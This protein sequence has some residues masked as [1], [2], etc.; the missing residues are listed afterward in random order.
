MLFLPLHL[1]KRRLKQRCARVKRRITPGHAALHLH[2]HAQRPRRRQIL[3]VGRTGQLQKQRI[4]A[5]G[6]QRLLP[7]HARG[8]SVEDQVRRRRRARQLRQ[9]HGMRSHRVRRLH[10]PLAARADDHERAHRAKPRAERPTDAPVAGDQAGA[11]QQRALHPLHRPA[12]GALGGQ[13][14]VRPQKRLVPP[15]IERM[16]RLRHVLRSHPATVHEQAARRNP[17]KHDL[18]RHALVRRRHNQHSVAEAVRPREHDHVR[19]VVPREAAVRAP[20][21]LPSGVKRRLRR[22]LHAPVSA[23]GK[24]SQFHPLPARVCKARRAHAGQTG[25]ARR[26]LLF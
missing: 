3:A 24:Q 15:R 19:R 25:R 11:A 12:N 14:R 23:N 16:P 8:H 17:C 2:A 6:P 1:P 4:R 9:R 26:Q 20:V 13:R 22:A 7:E 18:P 5:H 10:L 21:A